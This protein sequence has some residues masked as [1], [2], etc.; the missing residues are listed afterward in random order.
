[1][2]LDI[3]DLLST[4]EFV[5]VA[6]Q[7]V[8]DVEEF[9]KYYL[10]E[11][12]KEQVILKTPEEE[13]Q[14]SQKPSNL[15]KTEY[16]KTLVSIDSRDRISTLYPKSNHFKIFLGKTFK[17]VKSIEMVSLEF[18][19]TD[20][21]INTSNNKIYWRDIDDILNDNLVNVNGNYNYP[22]YTAEFRNGSYTAAALEKEIQDSMN[23]IKRTNEDDFHYFIVNMDVDTDIVEFIS[24][25]LLQLPNNPITTTVSSNIISVYFPN[26]GFSTD[27]TI[28]L[29]GAKTVAGINTSTLNQFHTIVVT[30]VNTFTFEV[31]I[32]A[33]ETIVSTGG[34]V[35][36]V[37]IKT[38][39]QFLNGEYSNTVSKNIGYL[40]ENSS[41]LITTSIN[42]MVNIT[43]MNI[44]INNSQS[45][46]LSIL[47]GTI[48]DLGIIIG[49]SF[50]SSY[51]F[52]VTS[53]EF[54]IIK[55]IVP[56]LQTIT[57][58]QDSLTVFTLNTDLGYFNTISYTEYNINGFLVTT[59]TNHNYITEDIGNSINID[60]NDIL[61]SYFIQSIIN[62]TQF[63]LTGTLETI[64]T[65]GATL[66][67]KTPLTSH[68]VYIDSVNLK[69]IE[70]SGLW[71]T[72][73]TTLTDHLLIKGDTFNFNNTLPKL[74]GSFTVYDV[75][76]STNFLVQL[77]MTSLIIDNTSFLGTGLLELSFP[78]HNFNSILNF[79]NGTPF[80]ISSNTVYPIIVT[81]KLNH[82]LQVGSIVRFCNTEA[83]YENS[84]MVSGIFPSLNETV[85]YVY[86]VDSSDT[87]T[88][89]K[90]LDGSDTFT[91]I[92][93][94]SLVT[95]YIGL[96][97]DFRLYNVESIGNI[98]SDVLNSYK[99]TVRD[100][101]DENTFNF[102]V[103]D[104]Y[105]SK[106]EIGGGSEIYISSLYHGFNTM[107]TNV[108][109]G[110]VSRSINLQG[111]D[112]CFLTCP[113]LETIINTGNIKGIFSRISLDQPPGYVCFKYL[114]NPKIYPVP[115]DKLE[116]LEISVV[117]HSGI[118][119][120]FNDLDYSFTL[121]ITEVV[122]YIKSLNS[123]SK[124]IQY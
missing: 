80:V 114:S 46:D 123:S 96:N 13:Q 53:V 22:V 49:I 98:S 15:I 61:S 36:K 69:H 6:I 21:V 67:R 1:M 84:I 112:Y 104:V 34:N 111:E 55:V 107:Q 106:F 75:L 59:S 99:F 20:A 44:K 119:Y 8:E 11:K 115:L 95:G 43:Q 52:I 25:R 38:P 124:R 16:I 113:Q 29:V 105:A 10:E 103:N 65:S 28:Y 100:I 121:E 91:P 47:V 33:S 31:N 108:R 54:N 51:T 57:D 86:S 94:S 19:N 23:K 5:P 17:H 39:F 89:L 87:F 93:I 117:Y 4:N 101:I 50:I 92:T 109:N 73:I 60:L 79:Q 97:V 78:N 27:D 12:K 3:N 37:G 77:E 42:T 71:Y 40:E 68:I 45:K 118:L 63:I 62:N 83:V 66:S 2:D 88:I 85:S 90:A 9:K 30:S 32:K 120:E 35:V 7:P 48:V 110:K 56:D 58:I 18:P 14:E 64:Y 72:L 26:H 74:N 116:E 102:M 41:E 76:N 70:I 82:N 24:L 81:T 122:D